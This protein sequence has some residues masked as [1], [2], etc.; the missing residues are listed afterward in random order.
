MSYR[1]YGLASEELIGEAY[2]GLMHSVCQF[3]PD[4]GVRFAT[5]AIWWVRATILECILRNR[6]PVK[7]GTAASQKKVFVSLRSMHGHL[8]EF[9]NFTL[10]SKHVSSMAC[11]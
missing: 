6:S 10:K 7:M 2:V 5:Y 8:R 9:H 3:D 1:G 4:R 11:S